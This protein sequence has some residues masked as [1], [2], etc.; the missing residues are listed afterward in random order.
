MIEFSIH[1]P[2]VFVG[3]L[4]GYGVIALIWMIISFKNADWGNGWEM[5]YNSGIEEGIR[6]AKKGERGEQ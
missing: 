3:F 6:R 5:G 2:S 4:I 1:L